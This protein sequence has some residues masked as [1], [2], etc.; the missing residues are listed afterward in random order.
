MEDHE[1][2]DLG[3]AVAFSWFVWGGGQVGGKPLGM[4]QQSHA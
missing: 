1:D 4:Q 3:A 2:F